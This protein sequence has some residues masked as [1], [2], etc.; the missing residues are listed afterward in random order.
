MRPTSQ[1]VNRAAGR[2]ALFRLV[3][4]M[5]LGLG[6]GVALFVGTLRSPSGQPVQSDVNSATDTLTDLVNQQG[7]RFDAGQLQGHYAV[8][9]FG[10]TSCPDA[11]PTA[12]Y[13]LTL[14]LQQLDADAQRIQPVFVTVD[15]ARDS[16][17]QLADYLAHF[18]ERIIGLTGT[19]EALQL[20][21]QGF[22]VL[23]VEHRDDSLP[24]GYTM[25]H[26]N[27]FLLLSP[28][29]KMLMRLPADQSVDA[30]LEQLRGLTRAETV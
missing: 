29:G 14:A 12:L 3:L 24:G 10:F 9:Y 5:L 6:V 22:G 1:S 13:N 15:P 18:S 11:C 20:A 26:S 2:R 8:L 16:P 30:L 19:M 27:E 4:V 7:G 28:T 17:G 25:D 23:A 21:E